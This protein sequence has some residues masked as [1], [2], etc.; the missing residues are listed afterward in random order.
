MG[1]P[2][3]QPCDGPGGFLV[4][5]DGV[6]SH[7]R[8]PLLALL[9]WSSLGGSR[10]LCS[11]PFMRHC[12]SWEQVAIC[13]IPV[14]VFLRFPVLKDCNPSSSRVGTI[15]STRVRSVFLLIT[16]SIGLKV[17]CFQVVLPWESQESFWPHISQ[18]SPVPAQGWRPSA[19]ALWTLVEN[20]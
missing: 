8:S 14:T 13:K 3:W 12:S 1:H 7:L 20:K 17:R 16:S 19:I 6:L 10:C 15:G 4:S 11:S 18:H 9:P 5:L 2:S